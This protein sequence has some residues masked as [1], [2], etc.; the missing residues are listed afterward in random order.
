MVSF[1][2]R[3]TTKEELVNAGYALEY[4]DSWQP[5]T[6]LYR[7]ADGLNVEG[8]VVYPHGSQVKGVPGNPEYVLRKAKIGFLP[9]PPNEHCNCRWCVERKNIKE[10]EAVTIDRGSS[11]SKK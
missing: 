10:E 9:Y 5:K 4:I 2:D 6:V 8:D 1:K 7:H 11:S 3:N